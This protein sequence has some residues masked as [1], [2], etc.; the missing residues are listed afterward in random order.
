MEEMIKVALIKC[1]NI[2]NMLEGI[3]RQLWGIFIPN[4]V[5]EF[6]V[7][8]DNVKSFEK[9]EREREKV[10]ALQRL[11]DFPL[12]PNNTLHEVMA[13]IMIEK[14]KRQKKRMQSRDP[15]RDW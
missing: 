5:E 4:T 14:K 15:N 2:K 7:T 3:P 13:K 11:Y 8:G 10:I 1:E 6:K 12:R 9:R